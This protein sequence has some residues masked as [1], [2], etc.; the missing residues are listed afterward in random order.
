LGIYEQQRLKVSEGITDKVAPVLPVANG[1]V[2]VFISDFPV[3]QII[4]ESP[5]LT[6]SVACEVALNVACETAALPVEIHQNAVVSPRMPPN[7]TSILLSF[8]DY[9]S[10]IEAGRKK[11]PEMY[12]MGAWQLMSMLGWNLPDSQDCA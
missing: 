4:T 9:M 12:V 2:D 7:F 11:R 3:A 5:V 10:S 1:V 6:H 8:K